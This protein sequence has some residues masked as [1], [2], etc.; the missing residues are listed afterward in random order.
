MGGPGSGRCWHYGSKET[1]DCYRVLDVRRIS[2][3]GLL[4]AGK[5]FVWQWKSGSQVSASIDIRTDLDRLILS[6]RYRCKGKDWIDKC[7]SVDIDWTP[8]N[9]GGMRPWF[10]CPARGCGRRCAILYG[11][12]VFA[13][14]ECFG[15]AYQTQRERFEDRTARR[16]NK[17]RERLGWDLGVLN[18]SGLRPKGMH[19]RTFDRLVA[20][21]DSDV[22]ACLIHLGL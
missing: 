3:D 6:Y 16:A 9:F 13:C 11:G 12:P 19:R 17:I 4:T 18:A 15:L 20:Q 21:H 22:R 14:R 1:T 7:L 2:R 8:C 5:S 10:R